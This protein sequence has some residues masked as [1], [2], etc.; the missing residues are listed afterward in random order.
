M[1]LKGLG[2]KNKYQE[3]R[4]YSERKVTHDKVDRDLWI[5]GLFAILLVI[6]TFSY[7]YYVLGGAR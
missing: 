5:V 3:R 4:K 7:I 2:N 6:G 1:G